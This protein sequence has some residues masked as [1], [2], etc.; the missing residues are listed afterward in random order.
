[1]K[2]LIIAEAGVNHDG[3]LEVARRLVDVAATAGETLVKFQTFSADRLSG[4]AAP[5]AEYQRSATDA[6]ESQHA[7]LRR[8]ELTRDM[9]EALIAHCAA[10]GVGFL[11]TAFDIES[12]DLLRSLG[13]DRCKIPS[14]EITNL[15]YCAMSAASGERCCCRP[16][17][18]RSVK[19]KP[20][21]TPWKTRAHRAGW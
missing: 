16:A 13:V 10:R 2:T 21:S 19:S 20:R 5:K 15:P 12:F 11:S 6:D 7:M 9:H 14:G 3:D 17:W 18:P 8:L 4:A 1:M